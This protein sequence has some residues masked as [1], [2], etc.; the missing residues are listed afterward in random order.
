MLKRW[1]QERWRIGTHSKGDRSLCHDSITEVRMFILFFFFFFTNASVHSKQA[2]GVSALCTGVMWQI[3]DIITMSLLAV[4]DIIMNSIIIII[5][6]I[7]T[8]YYNIR[9]SVESQPWEGIWILPRA[10]VVRLTVNSCNWLLKI[11]A[12]QCQA[13]NSHRSHIS[14]RQSKWATNCPKKAKALLNCNK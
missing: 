10:R 14:P 3:S 6:I 13:L 4:Y 1:S 11:W 7:I 9:C 12:I 5:T 8:Y 2:M